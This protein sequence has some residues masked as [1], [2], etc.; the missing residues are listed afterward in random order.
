MLVLRSLLVL[1]GSTLMQA[2]EVFIAE[3]PNSSGCSQLNKE[4]SP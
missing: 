4:E 3:A 2:V 1:G